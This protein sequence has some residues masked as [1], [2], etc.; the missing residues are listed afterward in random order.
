ML[1][2]T[3]PH[4]PLLQGGTGHDLL[5]LVYISG[6]QLCPTWFGM[7]KLAGIRSSL[8]LGVCLAAL[9]NSNTVSARSK[10]PTQ[11]TQSPPLGQNGPFQGI[12]CLSL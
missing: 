9:I 5:Y 12:S 7:I 2:A 3:Y 4:V 1:N 8:Y 10:C 11:G 6:P